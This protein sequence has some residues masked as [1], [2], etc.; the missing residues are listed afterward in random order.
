MQDR[1]ALLC[2]KGLML[3]QAQVYEG[4]FENG[5]FLAAGQTIH[6]PERKMVYITILGEP[7]EVVTES[8]DYERRM[9]WLKRLDEAIRL[10]ADEELQYIPRSQQMRPPVDFA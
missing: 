9:D 4:Y 8:S 5:S 3:M 7:T 6:I 10:S 2:A 1:A